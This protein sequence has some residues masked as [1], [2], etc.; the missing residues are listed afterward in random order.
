MARPDPTQTS[1]D[2]G[3]GEDPTRQSD[4]S[5]YRQSAAAKRLTLQAMEKG[6]RARR[7]ALVLAP[8]AAIIFAAYWYLTDTVEDDAPI[9]IAAAV[10]L[11]AIGWR[12]ARDIGNALGPRL[13]SRFDPGTAST[14]GFFARLTTLIIVLIVAFRIVDVKPE[15]VAI[16]GAV[17]AV[18]IGLAAQSTLGNLI[19]GAVLLMSRPFRIGQ[20]VR[21]E[22]GSLGG[23]P[24]GTVASIGLLYTTLARGEET[25]WFQT[26]AC[27]PPRSFRCTNRRALSCGRDCEQV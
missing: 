23:K 17:T 13:L 26:A 15:T 21:M 4:I 16:G 27:S 11:A 1:R 9:R 3:N 2:P 12:F 25:F 10:L 6:R 14:V 24:E 8:L 7:E 20:R 5:Y 22:G 18:I 19:A